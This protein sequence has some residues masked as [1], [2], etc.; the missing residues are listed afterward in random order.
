MFQTE[1]R[2][3]STQNCPTGCHILGGHMAK[4]NINQVSQWHVGISLI[5]FKLVYYSLDIYNL[6]CH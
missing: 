1:A 5:L 6:I 3:V 4:V 2:L